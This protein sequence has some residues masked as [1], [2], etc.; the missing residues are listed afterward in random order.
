M[1]DRKCQFFTDRSTTCGA[2]AK[3]LCA[4]TPKK[5]SKIERAYCGLHAGQLGR[6]LGPAEWTALVPPTEM[7]TTG[8][9]PV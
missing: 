2:P 1:H 3:W 7:P 9:N 8:T 5:A 4:T 6:V